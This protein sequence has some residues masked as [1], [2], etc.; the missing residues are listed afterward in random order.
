MKKVFIVW[1][2]ELQLSQNLTKALD[3]E[4][5][6]FYF[7]ENSIFLRLV[8]LRYVAQSIATLVYL[9]K[10]KPKVILVQN[11]PVFA[12]VTVL[13]FCW[14]S[15]S[16]M[17]IDSHT[18]AF[19]DKKW[20]F[21]FPLFKFV[22]R[23]AI[24]NTC[25]N[26]KNLEILKNWGISPAMVMQFDNP[27]YKQNTLEQPILDLKLN[28]ILENSKHPIM[29]VN[30]FANDDDVETVIET[31]K[32][33]P[34]YTFYITGDSAEYQNQKILQNM[35]P[36]IF[37][38]GYLKHNEF[39]KLMWRCRVILAFTTRKDTVLWSIREIMALNKPY[40]TTDSDVL[41]Y[42]HGETGLFSKSNP[43]ELKIR[44]E[45]AERNK[46]TIKEK[47]EIFLKKDK[48]RWDKEIETLNSILNES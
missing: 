4:L 21:F 27:I 29:M 47:I 19:L 2:R 44:I 39:L 48:E 40:V 1:G 18:A 10:N 35:S 14:L 26:Y 28:K 37:L 6:Q 31:A 15:G 13:F 41:R 17:A 22:A 34:K 5:K 46:K 36:N 43:E 32:L 9:S 3:M 25:H 45:E 30:R 8:F 16:R 33:L 38:T 7:K 42:Y 24:V 11:P 20:R 12:S 23:R